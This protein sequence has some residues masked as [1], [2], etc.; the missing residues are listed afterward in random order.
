VAPTTSSS[1][2]ARR[3]RHA[4]A[5]QEVRLGRERPLPGVE[6]LV[7]R[8]AAQVRRQPRE[9]QA[10]DVVVVSQKIGSHELVGTGSWKHDGSGRSGPV[11]T[12]REWHDNS[13]AGYTF[14]ALVP[15]PPAPAEFGMT[16]KRRARVV[17]VW[18][19]RDPPGML[20]AGGLRAHRVRAGSV[21]DADLVF[22][23][24]HHVAEF[25]L[26]VVP[27]DLFCATLVVGTT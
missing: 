12:L 11:A 25:D 6:V 7:R 24:P 27:S 17:R 20:D 19:L 5:R 21:A 23:G 10:L 3:R 15:A 1:T 2:R 18:K 16:F 4:L 13:A 9:V 26:F 14:D 8:R 22:D